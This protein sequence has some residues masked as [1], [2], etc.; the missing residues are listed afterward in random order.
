MRGQS[1]LDR[2][3][4]SSSLAPDQTG[5]DWV[6]L[7]LD[8]GRDLM[9][10]RLRGRTA[11]GRIRPGNPGGTATAPP[12]LCRLTAWSLEPLDTWTSPETER[13]TRSAGAAGSR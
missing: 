8:D 7:Q 2:E 1:W 6:S 9:L 3:I 11:D 4:F 5:W 10:Y 12:A 13:S